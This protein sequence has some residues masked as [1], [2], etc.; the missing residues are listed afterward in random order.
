MVMSCGVF[1]SEALRLM[2]AALDEAWEALPLDQ[3]TTEARERIAYA[4]VSLATNWGRDRAAHLGAVSLA[5][6]E[7]ISRDVD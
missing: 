7:R 2:Q 4:V 5:E 3:R 6:R 1:D